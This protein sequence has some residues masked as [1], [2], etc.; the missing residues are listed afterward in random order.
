MRF[1]E[2]TAAFVVLYIVLMIPTYLLPYLRF[3][4]GIGLAVEG[5]A[6]AAAGASLGLLA[7]QLV[8]LVILIAITWF[9]GNFMAKKWLVIFPILATV[10]DLVP[11]L[12]AVPLVPTVLHLLAIILGVVGSSAAA[13]EKPAQ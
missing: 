7:V 13:S 11:G 2:N 12:S 1:I 4:T 6:D 8:F 10:F 9:R 3:A 5:E